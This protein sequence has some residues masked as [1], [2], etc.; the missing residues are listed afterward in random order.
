MLETDDLQ[1]SGYYIAAIY[2]RAALPWL[3][4]SY[5]IRKKWIGSFFL[6]EFEV[7]LEFR[8]MHM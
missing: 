6:N 7:V 5:Y 3:H 1:Y 2:C 4:L 8:K